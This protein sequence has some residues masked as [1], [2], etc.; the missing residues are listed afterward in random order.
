MASLFS[1]D[2]EA[3]ILKTATNSKSISKTM[4]TSRKQSSINSEL[5]EISKNVVA[6]FPDSPAILINTEEQL[7]EYVTALIAAGY[8]GIDTETTGLDRYYDHIVG[9]SLYYPGGVEAYIPSRHMVPI[10]NTPYKNQLTYEQIAKEFRRIADSNV[11]LLFANADFDLSMIYKDIGVDFCDNF[12]YDVIL[13][14]RCLKENE[15]HNGLKELY[16]KYVLTGSGDPKKFTDFFS[17]ELFPYCDP[18]V[19][20]LYAANDAKITYDL[21]RWQL[22]YTQKDHPKCKKSHLEAIADLIWNVEFPLVKSCQHMHR[23]GI[24][25]DKDIAK[26]IGK[27]YHSQYDKELEKVKSMVQDIIDSATVVRGTKARPFTRGEDFNPTSPLHVKY[28]LYTLMNLPEPKKGGT[29]KDALA[30]INLPITKQIVKVRSLSTLI[31]TFVDKMPEATTPDGK[32]HAQFKQ[33]GAGTG[34]MCIAKGTLISLVDGFVPIED[35]KRGDLIYCYNLDTGKIE[36]SRVLNRWFTGSDR[37]CVSVKYKNNSKNPLIYD[38]L[39]IICTP[40]HQILKNS[41]EWCRADALVE[42]DQLV[43]MCR[44]SFV[45]S[46]EPCGKHDVYDI[47]VEGFHNFFARGICVHNSSANPNMQN[48]PS[49]ADDIRHMFR[50]TP[51]VVQN[52]DC[53]ITDG[54]VEV[55]VNHFDFVQV[56]NEF[57]EVSK[58]NEESIVT[59]LVNKG[60]VQCKLIEPIHLLPNSCRVSLK[61]QYILISLM[62]KQ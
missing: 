2:E 26:I 7:H 44:A 49:H 35:V 39:E 53:H 3:A 33:I 15:L 50:S 46:V 40:E 25:L 12:Y 19:A 52:I 11:R 23:R 4:S 13:A 62:A 28:L 32:I 48:I 21:F 41:G 17:P 45:S 10:F 54:V 16:N 5:Q 6:Y 14:W 42:G 18:E 56:D 22:P 27:K 9:A 20:K 51:E 1:K 24:S 47:E 61:L 8:A 55:E 34:R 38:D 60:E 37:D 43:D 30:D 58:L 36:I 31:G 57:V 59:V 29:G